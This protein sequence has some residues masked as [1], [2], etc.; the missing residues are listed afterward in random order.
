MTDIITDLNN[1]QMDCQTIEL[2]ANGA[3]DLPN[4]GHP[5]GTVTSR[6][7]ATFRTLANILAAIAV[8]TATATT[9][10]SSAYGSALRADAAAGLINSQWTPAILF[11]PGVAGRWFDLSNMATLFSD[12]AGTQ[13][14]VIDGPVGKMLDRSANAGHWTAAS[15]GARPTLRQTIEGVRYLEF[16]GVADYGDAVPFAMPQPFMRISLVRQITWAANSYLFSNHSVGAGGGLQ[17]LYTSPNVTINSGNPGFGGSNDR[18][19]GTDM[20]LT[21]L[22]SGA[23][24][25]MRQDDYPPMIASGGTNPASGW[26]LGALWSNTSGDPSYY[27][28]FRFYGGI[29]IGRELSGAE[30]ALIRGYYRSQRSF[31]NSVTEIDYAGDSLTYGLNSSSPS[32]KSMPARVQARMGAGYVSRNRGIPS[33]ISSNIA[34][35]FDG[36]PLTVALTNNALPGTGTVGFTVVSPL[37]EA[38]PTQAAS[39]PLSNLNSSSFVNRFGALLTCDDGT[40]IP[41]AIYVGN[42]GVYTFTR[43]VAGQPLSVSSG[44]IMRVKQHGQDFNNVVIWAGRNNLN[45]LRVRTDV[46]GIFARYKAG[47]IVL[48]LTTTRNGTEDTNSVNLNAVLAHNTYFAATYGNLFIDVYAWLRDTSSAGPFAALGKTPT[49]Q[50]T[51]DIAAG[52]IPQVWFSNDDLHFNDDGYDAISIPVAAKQTALGW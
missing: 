10:A 29:M 5:N 12:L 2:V 24:S 45:N 37:N 39:G 19:V 6:L 31:I 40:V 16:D 14:A 17:Q 23:A 4:P 22:H 32:T 7:G 18:A 51:A 28:N 38:T 36:I 13:A 48:G 3:A 44:S 41:G 11:G 26:R 21:E 47:K 50:D 34:T 43:D 49:A 9:A 42:A 8:S 27:A 52:R 46:A 15:V 30:Q 1:A 33:Q 35:R 25:Y 20:V